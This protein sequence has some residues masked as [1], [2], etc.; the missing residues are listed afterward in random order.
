[1]ENMER[2]LSKSINDSLISKPMVSDKEDKIKKNLQ[3]K[4]AMKKLHERLFQERGVMERI[5]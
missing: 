4:K 5:K 3:H 1:M 2:K